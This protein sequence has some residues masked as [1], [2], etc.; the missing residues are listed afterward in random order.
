MAAVAEHRAVRADQALAHGVEISEGLSVFGAS[1]FPAGQAGL[2]DI[3]RFKILRQ[4]IC[5]LLEGGA[6]IGALV[7]SV[8]A[9]GAEGVAARQHS[10]TLS[11]LLGILF[12]TNLTCSEYSLLEKTR[13]NRN[14]MKA[15]A[16]CVS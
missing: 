6:I 7:D 4:Q 9:F 13:M 11:R 5:W 10:W 15:N 1:E 14:Y 12:K 8:E 2:H 16:A 3:Q